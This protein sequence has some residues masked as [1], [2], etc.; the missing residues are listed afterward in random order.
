MKKI[1]TIVML[2][3]LG[4]SLA[5]CSKED[6]KDD[7]YAVTTAS[8]V[9]YFING[10]QHYANPQTEEEWSFFLDRMFAL[11]EEEHSVRFVRTNAS[12]QVCSAK[13]VLTY[14]TNNYTSAKKWA[15]QKTLE[16]YDVT[17]TYDQETGIYTC[18]AIR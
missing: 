1:K 7:T 2:A 15:L 18:I 4:L 6:V 17:I 9:T 16:G 3:A 13:E 14:E 10:E 5:S 8:S 12:Q 11:A